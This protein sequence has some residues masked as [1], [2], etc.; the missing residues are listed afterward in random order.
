MTGDTTDS[1]PLPSG[2]EPTQAPAH[3]GKDTDTMPQASTIAPKTTPDV[4]SEIALN[5]VP[6]GK[7][8]TRKLASLFSALVS[9]AMLVAVFLKLRELNFH[10]IWTMIPVS[11]AFWATFVLNYISPPIS[12]WVIYRRLWAIPVS[13]I[14]ALLRKQV[15][16][17]LLLSYLGEV[18]FY[19][20]ARARLGM[21]TA[22]FG[23]IKDMTILSALTGNVATLA[24]LVWAWPF[25]AS[26]GL[27]MKTELVFSSLGVVLLT[28]FVIMLFRQQLF[29]L[30]R[31]ELLI[32]TGVHLARI[33]VY[34][35]LTA[36]MWHLVLPE[37]TYA[38]WLVLATL[39]MLISRL[40][41]VP[42]KEVVFAGLT[43]FL[44]GNDAQIAHLFALMA[45]I[46]PLAHVCVGAVLA[47][48]DVLTSRSEQ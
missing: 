11:A 10:T 3:A 34:V 19:A 33:V 43:V 5:P 25:V 16:N 1:G 41:L 30:P 6:A 26:G 28:S 44:L 40:P 42:N 36:L 4:G 45:A 37:V 32:I 24:M 14:A 47:T 38:V 27:G 35:G 48:A 21:V 13:G 31:R 20:W 39:R 2:S 15:S 12:E 23:A 22:P 17:E 18:Q 9:A 29:T 8:G 46:Y 7:T